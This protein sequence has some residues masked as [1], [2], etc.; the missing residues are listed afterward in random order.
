TSWRVRYAVYDP[1]SRGHTVQFVTRDSV[2]KNPV[3][4]NLPNGVCIASAASHI[5]CD[6]LVEEENFTW[7]YT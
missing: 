5:C 6:R 3:W 2:T 1:A 4:R 7:N